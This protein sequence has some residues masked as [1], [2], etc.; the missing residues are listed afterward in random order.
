MFWAMCDLLLF[1]SYRKSA[2]FNTLYVFYQRQRFYPLEQ[3][4][5]NIPISPRFL[6]KSSS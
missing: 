5:K 2:V 1:T 3:E 6:A 4:P